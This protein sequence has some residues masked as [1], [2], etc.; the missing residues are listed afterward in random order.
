[1]CGSAAIAPHRRAGRR[2]E[3]SGCDEARDC[4]DSRGPRG[5]NEPAHRARRY[6]C[7]SYYALNELPQPQP[8]VEFGFEKVKPE[9]C[10]DET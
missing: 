3:P 8:P 2:K 6:A 7:A 1:M 9:P 4:N 10:I 5:G